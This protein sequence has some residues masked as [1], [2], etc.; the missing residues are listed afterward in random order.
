MDTFLLQYSSLTENSHIDGFA[1]IYYNYVGK[2]FVTN[3]Q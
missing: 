2:V 3:M 1:T